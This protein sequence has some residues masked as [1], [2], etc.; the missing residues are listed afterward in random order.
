MSSSTKPTTRLGLAIFLILVLLEFAR[1]PTESDL[2]LFDSITETLVSTLLVLTGGAFSGFKPDSEAFPTMTMLMVKRIGERHGLR[3]P[4][5]FGEAFE[6]L[7][8]N[9][10]LPRFVVVKPPGLRS[11]EVRPVLFWFHKGGFVVGNHWDRDWLPRFV[12][13]GFV[14]VSV[15]YPLSPEFVFPAALNSCV[16]VVAYFLRQEPALARQLLNIDIQR[17]FVGGYSAGGNLA[18]TVAIRLGEMG[19]KVRGH[20]IAA[21]TMKKHDHANLHE[22]MKEF[23]SM[24]ENG[25]FPTLTIDDLDWFWTCYCGSNELCHYDYHAQPLLAGIE[26]LKVLSPA[27]LFVGSRDMLR[28]ENI[29]YSK[30]LTEAGVPNALILARGTHLGSVWFDDVSTAKA[31]DALMHC[32]TQPLQEVCRFADD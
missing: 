2:T 25:H 24:K 1:H 6:G 30:R 26:Q 21:G 27:L 9:A 18:A 22:E 12:K 4:F 5:W 31:I 15:D 8:G 13:K 14:V 19:I 16:D 32:A 11:G 7:G 23:P 10:S 28:D 17:A 3:Y 29:L 20:F